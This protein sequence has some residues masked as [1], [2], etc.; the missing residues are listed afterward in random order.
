MNTADGLTKAMSSAN[1]RNLLTVNTSRI[2][3]EE[4]K[5]IRK[6]MPASKHYIACRETIQGERIWTLTCD[7]RLERG[8][9]HIG[10]WR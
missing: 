8:E 2:V 1:R 5:E 10:K 6:K 4:K 3:T 9:V 7:E